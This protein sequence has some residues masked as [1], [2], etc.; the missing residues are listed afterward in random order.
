MS[1]S[2]LYTD[3]GKKDR[4]IRVFS[5]DPG[6]GRVIGCG[7]KILDSWAVKGH[8]LTSKSGEFRQTGL[9]L[10]DFSTRTQTEPKLGFSGRGPDRKTGIRA[11]IGRILP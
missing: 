2:P 8:Y 1:R 9:V 6:A 5:A 3:P 4:N 11:R 10:G 7:K